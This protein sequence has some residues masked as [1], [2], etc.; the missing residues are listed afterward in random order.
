MDIKNR[1]IVGGFFNVTRLR[2]KLL[3]QLSVNKSQRNLAS[4]DYD[5]ASGCPVGLPLNYELVGLN[6]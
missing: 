3:G 4:P 1:Q 2:F 5:R 6:Q